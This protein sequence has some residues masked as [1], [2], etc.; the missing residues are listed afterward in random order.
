[1][2]GPLLCVCVCAY[3]TLKK[4]LSIDNTWE[5]LDLNVSGWKCFLFYRNHFLN[6]DELKDYSDHV[7]DGTELSYED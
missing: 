1:M 3:I 4:A 6:P 7:Y 2:T 5:P